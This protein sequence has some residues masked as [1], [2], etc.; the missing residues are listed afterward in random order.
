MGIDGSPIG[1]DLLIRYSGGAQQV[2]SL[3]GEIAPINGGEAAFCFSN[4]LSAVSAV[5]F[6]GDYRSVF[7]SF[8]YEGLA[9]FVNWNTRRAERAWLLI[10]T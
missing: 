3:S 4:D 5:S 9:N 10:G 8:G 6:A 7:F 1:D 2:L